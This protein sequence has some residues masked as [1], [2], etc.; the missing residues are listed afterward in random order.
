[1]RCAFQSE[2]ITGLFFF[3]NEA[4]NPIT[5]VNVPCCD[6]SAF[7]TSVENIAIEM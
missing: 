5:L 1:M 7:G 4:G 3:E 2:G 6:S